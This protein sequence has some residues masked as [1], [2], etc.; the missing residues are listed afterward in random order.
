MAENGT[1]GSGI[2][3]F[4]HF[5]QLPQNVHNFVETV[6]RAEKIT[7]GVAEPVKEGKLKTVSTGA[8]DLTQHF[9][10]IPGIE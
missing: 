9:T 7:L 4:I 10:G 1:V 8:E 2:F 6:R 3:Q 5:G